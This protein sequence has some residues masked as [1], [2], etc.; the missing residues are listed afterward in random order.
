MRFDFLEPALD[1]LNEAIAWYN[2]QRPGL[3]DEFA[4]EVD[5][6]IAR[7]LNDPTSWARISRNAR[8][9]R[10]NRFPYGIIYTVEEDEVLII[11]VM[12]LSRR[13]GYWKGRL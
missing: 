13:P 2:Q 5:K 12:H 8:R 1:E 7:I 3:G 4:D 6:T 10:T 9:C 11:A